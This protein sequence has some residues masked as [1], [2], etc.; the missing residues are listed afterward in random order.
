MPTTRAQ[1]RG[2]GFL[3]LFRTPKEV[4]TL[5]LFSSFA[6]VSLFFHFPFFIFFRFSSED[7]QFYIGLPVEII[8]PVLETL[9]KGEFPQLRSLE[10][11]LTP[12]QIVQARELNP[13]ILSLIL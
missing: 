8:R 1:F 10:V 11:E 5:L 12:V 3:S 9:R 13:F 7:S 4:R 2:S 6:P